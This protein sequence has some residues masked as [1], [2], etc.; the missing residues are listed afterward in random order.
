MS[1]RR[2]G[3]GVSSCN[4]ARP[5]EEE[6]MAGDEQVVSRVLRKW[7]QARLTQDNLASQPYF[8]ISGG[9]SE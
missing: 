6:T 9:R 3:V 7:V 4:W 2:F 5:R 1:G 8:F